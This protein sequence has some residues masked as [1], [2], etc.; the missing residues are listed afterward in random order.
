MDMQAE[1]IHMAVKISFVLRARAIAFTGGWER[2]PGPLQDVQLIAAWMLGLGMSLV[3]HTN[4][5]TTLTSFD[6][7]WLSWRI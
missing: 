5:L 3:K 7:K 6:K 2:R 1:F 4:M